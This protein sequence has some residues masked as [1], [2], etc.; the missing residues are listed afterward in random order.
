MSYE[1]NVGKFLRDHQDYVLMAGPVGA[2]YTAQRRDD[3]GRGTGPKVSAPTLDKLAERLEQQE[4][5][6]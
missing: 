1:Y 5:A 6:P 2:G 4:S 3:Q